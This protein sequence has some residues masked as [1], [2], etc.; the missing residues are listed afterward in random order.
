MSSCISGFYR[1]S[2]LLAI[3]CSPL[4]AAPCAAA[5]DAEP[6]PSY[7]V[8]LR[9]TTVSG[10]SS[11]AYMAVQFG[12]AHSAIVKG[13]GATAGGPYLCAFDRVP[14]LRGALVTAIARCMQGDPDF[15]RQ[16]ITPTQLNRM[17]RNTDAWARSGRIDATSRMQRQ[18]IWLFHGYNDGLVK[19]PVSDALY[20]YYTRFIDP[21]QIFYKD[22]LNAAHAQITVD[23]GEGATVCNLCPRTGGNFLNLCHDPAAG[24]AAYDAAGSMLELFHGPLKAADSSSIPA[25][26]IV[27]FA[28][29]EFALD[30]GAA[31]SPQRISMAEAGYAYVPD[32]CARGEPCRVHV[33]FHGCGQSAEQIG[34]AFYEHAGYNRWADAN[35]LIILYPQTQPTQPTPLAPLLPLNPRGCWDWWGYNDGLHNRGRFAT[36]AGLQIAAVRRMLDR[37]AGQYAGATP[38]ASVTGEFGP[39]ASLVVGD[40]THR[41][42]ALRWDRV[43]GAIGYHVYRSRASGGPYG[44]AQRLNARL[45]ESPMFVDRTVQSRAQYFYV[46]RAVSQS[47]R[48]SADSVEVGVLTATKPPPCDPFFSLRQGRPVTRTNMP[49]E[50]FCP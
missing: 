46:V 20:D 36:Q 6:L 30:G 16:A 18:R 12:V 23:C 31:A 41:Q 15:P 8:D 33:A 44:A 1:R 14:S 42:V 7:N 34:S 32:S 17:V 39:P 5:T 10:V 48:E 27:R 40:F 35:R 37:L 47:N 4:A 45:A 21:S 29:R 9:E 43:G 26:K 50:A 28:Q 38:S 3:L 24:N 19:A 25:G 2:M 49:T 11:G 22:N 13:V